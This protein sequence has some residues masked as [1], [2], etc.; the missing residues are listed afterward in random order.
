MRNLIKWNCQWYI[1]LKTIE[2][3]RSFFFPGFLLQNYYHCEIKCS[4]TFSE[5]LTIKAQKKTNTLWK[6]EFFFVYSQLLVNS[7]IPKVWIIIN[8]T[9]LFLMKGDL[10]TNMFNTA[11]HCQNVGMLRKRLWT[12]Y[13]HCKVELKIWTSTFIT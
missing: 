9:N 1:L 13:R 2:I 3:A 6:V 11:L 7:F 10:G 8:C 4:G 5:L 12:I